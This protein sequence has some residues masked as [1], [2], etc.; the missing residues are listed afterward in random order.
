MRRTDEREREEKE[1]LGSEA[2]PAW[3]SRRL[4]LLWLRPVVWTEAGQRMD[5]A[6]AVL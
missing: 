6:P 4:G 5:T 3:A 2:T 1:E